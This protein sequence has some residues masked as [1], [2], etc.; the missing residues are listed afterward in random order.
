MALVDSE[1]EANGE[2]A[3]NRALAGMARC[4]AV[5]QCE[6]KKHLLAV[7]KVPRLF[8]QADRSCAKDPVALEA[9]LP[10]NTSADHG[11]RRSLT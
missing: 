6:R 5:S 9:P 7:W 1:D 3:A 2:P 4:A 10:D 11:C 8:F